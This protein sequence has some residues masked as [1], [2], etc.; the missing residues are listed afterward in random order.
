[1]GKI[2]DLIRERNLPELMRLESGEPVCTLDDFMKRREEIKRI[3][4]EEEYG[5][6]PDRPEHLTVEVVDTMDSFC[7][8]KVALST[9][10]FTVTVGG[11][12]FTFPVYS[13][14]PKYIKGKMPAFVLMNFRPNVPDRYYPTEE[15]CDRGY[16]V[17][18]FCYKDVTS[19]DGD[20]KNGIAKLFAKGKRKKD[21]PGK[22][23][24]WAWAA[25]R[26]MDYIEILDNIDL[27]NVAILGHS[28]LGKT[29]LIVGAFDERF[30]YAI[31]NDSGTS[32]AAAARGTHGESLSSIVN[33]F[34]FWYCPKFLNT[35]TS[36][37]QDSC[38]D[39]HFLMALIPPRHLCV[40]SAKEDI[41]ADPEGEFLTELEAARAYELFGIPGLIHKGEIPKAKSVLGE[42]NA[43]YHIREGVH[44]LDREDWLVYM[45]YIDSKMRDSKN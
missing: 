7:A 3:L 4:Q 22:L 1:M 25:M 39:Q 27:D 6:F 18:S 43:L 5:F 32:G 10:N 23:V 14:I 28:R 44:Y 36:F 17:F 24:M 15:I 26:V 33:T 19:D 12:D 21:A 35:Y 29:A 16:A 38:F 8:G 41:W 13:A 34:P 9:L 37:E 45:D 40:G 2:E 42:G 20:F 30:K 11:E 31:S